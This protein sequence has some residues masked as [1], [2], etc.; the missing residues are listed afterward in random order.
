[1]KLEVNYDNHEV[2]ER[3]GRIE[4]S[5]DFGTYSIHTEVWMYKGQAEQVD[6]FYEKQQDGTYLNVDKKAVPKA[7]LDIL[8]GFSEYFWYEHSDNYTSERAL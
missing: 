2:V 8:N 7:T 1:M 6:L 5:F 4:G 3:E